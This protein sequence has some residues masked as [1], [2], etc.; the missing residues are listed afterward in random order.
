MSQS[1]DTF[2]AS[3]RLPSLASVRNVGKIYLGG[4]KI[5]GMAKWEKANTSS[6][7]R[8]TVENVL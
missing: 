1:F 8:G 6:W 4:E 7:I 5:L 2:A 3:Y